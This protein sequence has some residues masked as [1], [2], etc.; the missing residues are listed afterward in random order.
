MDDYRHW[1]GRAAAYSDHPFTALVGVPVR[2]GDEFLGVLN[3]HADSPRTFSAADAEL[4]SLFASQA[5]IAIRNA[6]LYEQA[7]QEI[8]E[9]KRLEH[10]SEERRLYLES[11]LISAPDA[12]VTL[13]AQH[14]IL[15]WN[16]GAEKLFGY[17]LEEAVGRNIDTLVVGPGNDVFEEATGFTSQVLA[18]M[19][20]PPTETVRYRKDGSPVDVILAGSPILLGD[21]VVG[22]VTIY[23]DITARVQA[24]VERERLLAAEQEQRELAEALGAAAAAVSSTLDFD[25][26]LDLIL[27]QTRRVVPSD[28]ANVMLIEKDQARVVRWQGHE[29]FGTEEF[30]STAVFPVSDVPNLAQMVEH[31]APVVTADTAADP[32][33]VRLPAQEWVRS[34]AG[35]PICV[36]DQV[37][38]FLN[39]DSATPDFFTPVHARRLQAF[40]SYAAY[41]IENARLYE[42]AQQEIAERR[43][44]EEGLRRRAAELA[45]LQ[46]TV[47]DITTPHGLS[48][49]LQDIVERAAFLLDA[50][51]GGLYLCDPDQEQARCV[52]SYNTPRDYT[53]TVLKYGEGAAGTVAQT[54]APLIIDDYRVWARRSPAYEE[55]QPFTAVLSVPMIWQN[56][57]TGVIHVIHGVQDQRFTQADLDL[58]TLFANHAA[59]A[60]ENTRLYEEA[61]QELAERKR[62][63]EALTARV[64]QLAALNYASYAVTASLQVDQVLAEIVSLTNRVMASDYATV[65]LIDETGHIAQSAEDLPGVPSI[66]IRARAGG[67]TEWIARSGQAVIIDEINEDGVIVSDLGAGAPRFVNPHVVEAGIQSVAGLPMIARENLL[68]VL[69]LHSLRP[70]AFRDQLPLLTTFAN[71]AATAIENARLYETVQQELV[72]RGERRRR[73]T[74][75]GGAYPESI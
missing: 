54:G 47:L 33:W 74:K 45:A 52:V 12:I 8:A 61:R 5:A 14:N 9:R 67:L 60:V 63:E 48:T 11:V 65:L 35:V 37:V 72:E 53:G 16:S 6:R 69:Y 13:D 10:K 62:A 4:L 40:A 7:Q 73:P 24:E 28:A 64:E 39:L 50:Q 34:Y 55:E 51:S 32:G 66:E 44:A 31:K 49:L 58:L 17:T 26:V 2:W 21:Q 25:Q 59:I 15:E 70:Y 18:G 43:R 75:I 19:S 56:Q 20:I 1:D 30:V 3:I 42:Q 41:A 29:R 38:G 36:R 68:G 57:V 27:E 71:Q 22:V 23:T 46:A